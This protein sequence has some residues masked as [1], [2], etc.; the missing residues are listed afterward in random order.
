MIAR[1]PSHRPSGAWPSSPAL[2]SVELPEFLAGSRNHWSVAVTTKARTAADTGG[3][4]AQPLARRPSLTVGIRSRRARRFDGGH[5]PCLRDRSSVSPE[6]DE[7][8][9]PCGI[10]RTSGDLVRL[11]GAFSAWDCPGSGRR[12]GSDGRGRCES[13]VVRRCVRTARGRPASSDGRRFRA[14]L[15]PDARVVAGDLVRLPRVR[16]AVGRRN[17]VA[18]PP[19]VGSDVRRWARAVD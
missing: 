3:I 1:S 11:S 4:P 6:V 9:M 18:E 2:S 7:A 8:G 14:A 19:S 10:Y 15:L 12:G 13:F 16:S 17:L 5:A